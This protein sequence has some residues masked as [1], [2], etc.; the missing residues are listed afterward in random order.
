VWRQRQQVGLVAAVILI[1]PVL[2]RAG[3]W[4]QEAGH[5]QLIFTTSHYQTSSGFDAS[6]INR[7]F[8]NQGKFRQI[9]LS[10]YFEYGV[11]RRYALIVNAN[12]PFLRYANADGSVSSAGF[13][14]VEIAVKRRMNAPESRW[15]LSGQ[16]T[17]MFPAYSASRNPAPGNHQEDVELRLL[18]GRG[19]IW[20]KRNFYWNVESAYRYRSG[21]PADQFRGDVTVGADITQRFSTLAQV[22]AIKGVRNGDPFDISNPNAQSD[23]DLYKV[24]L[25]LLATITRRVRLQAGWND[26]FSGR[27]TGRGHAV[28]LGLWKS[29]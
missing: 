6:G 20:S 27:N 3:A 14:D 1:S 9:A 29:F 11:T 16:F 28:I 12:A 26:S 17:V 24:Q 4:N 2:L 23:F 10:S 13:G 8:A 21:A 25:S 18:V 5:A 15:A 7:P 22:F 19:T